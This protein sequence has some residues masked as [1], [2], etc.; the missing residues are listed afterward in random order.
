MPHAGRFAARYAEHFGEPP[1][2]T[3][4]RAPAPASAT[5]PGAGR[6]AARSQL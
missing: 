4:A 5:M 1:S 3:L 6:A 2:A